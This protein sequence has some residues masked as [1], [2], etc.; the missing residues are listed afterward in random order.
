MII[1][2]ERLDIGQ[3]VA[4]R[5]AL[6]DRLQ[7]L[8][9]AGTPTRT[10]SRTVRSVRAGAVR[11]RS[12]RS[13]RSRCSSCSCR[14][15]WRS[16]SSDGWPSRPSSRW[17]TTSSSPPGCT[18]GRLRGLAG[19]GHRSADDPRVLAVRHRGR[20]RQGAR[21]HPRPAVAHLPDLRRG[22][23]PRGQ[24]DAHAVAEHLAD[25]GAAADR[26][27]RGRRG[28]A[29]RGGAWRPRPGAAGRHDHRCGVVG[30]AGH[31]DRRRPR[32]ARPHLGRAGA[33]GRG[34]AGEGR[35][36]QLRRGT[37][38]TPT[39]GEP[40]DVLDTREVAAAGARSGGSR[41]SAGAGSGRGATSPRPGARPSGKSGRPAG[42]RRK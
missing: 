27:V 24:P 8:G 5:Q 13:S 29:R 18:P 33:Q 23:Q 42:K 6:F 9:A 25:R 35:A 40:T 14:C 21:E 17:P 39:A 20:V 30:A 37:A 26:A 1:R 10:R 28:A 31:P 12:R 16:T 22:G 15:T 32:D 36:R 3:V 4:L 38:E 34:P 19:D 7:P 41:T 11:S 2:S